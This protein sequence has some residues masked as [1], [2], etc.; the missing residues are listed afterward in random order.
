MAIEDEVRRIVDA[1]M[2]RQMEPLRRA[3]QQLAEAAAV[4]TSEVGGGSGQSRRGPAKK[5]VATKKGRAGP[6]APGKRKCAIKGCRKDA[7][8]K[9]YCGAHYQK[10]RNLLAKK[11][12]AVTGWKDDAAPGTVDDVK[13]PPNPT[14][15]EKL[16]EG[17]KETFPASDPVS[18]AHPS[19]TAHDREKRLKRER[20]HQ[21]H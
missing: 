4:F 6:S 16:D 5:R 17:V 7:R 21:K 20:S 12:P 14:T 11:H 18:I 8:S 15:D 19:E 3:M 9:G 10:R 13:L 2:Q 1:E